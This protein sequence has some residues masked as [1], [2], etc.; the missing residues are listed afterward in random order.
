M[1]GFGSW[2]NVV[3]NDTKEIK[4]DQTDIPDLRPE[5]DGPLVKDLFERNITDEMILDVYNEVKDKEASFE[6]GGEIIPRAD[7]LRTAVTSNCSNLIKEIKETDPS[8]EFKHV[9]IFMTDGNGLFF[10]DAESMPLDGEIDVTNLTWEDWMGMHI[11]PTSLEFME[12]SK[13]AYTLLVHMTS[14]GDSKDEVN[15]KVAFKVL[16]ESIKSIEEN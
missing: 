16:M 7:N 14:Q 12:E 6:F 8:T 11:H 4:Q 3:D 5:P 2:F 10:M 1:S 9:S 15:G 13:L